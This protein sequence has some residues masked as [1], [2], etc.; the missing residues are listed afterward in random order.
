MPSHI[1]KLRFTERGLLPT[2]IN[3]IGFQGN[4]SRPSLDKNTILQKG[5]FLQ[6]YKNVY[7]CC[8]L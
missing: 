2:V 4:L 8:Y 6:N 3:T 7:I 1:F 5:S